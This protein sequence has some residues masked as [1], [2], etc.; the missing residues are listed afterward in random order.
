MKGWR[1]DSNKI[2]FK[3]REH[4]Y[5]GPTLRNHGHTHLPSLSVMPRVIFLP[6]N[7]NFN[8]KR[9]G[10]PV[11]ACLDP[12][13]HVSWQKLS[14]LTLSSLEA[15]ILFWRAFR[16]GC[17]WEH[18]SRVL[19]FSHKWPSNNHT[20]ILKWSLRARSS[21]WRRGEGSPQDN[22]G[23]SDTLL[24]AEENQIIEGHPRAEQCPCQSSK[25]RCHRV[26]FGP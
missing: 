3:P 7:D 22:R 16:C 5:P 9:I 1:S 17:L 19:W 6:W 12:W 20:Q 2:L 24:K 13:I 10:C 25:R 21:I 4:G 26:M 15:F 23:D 11:Y 18:H 14:S 8:H